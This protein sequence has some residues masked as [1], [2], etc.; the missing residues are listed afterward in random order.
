MLFA[1]PGWPTNNNPRSPASVTTQ[2][3]IKGR[4]PTNFAAI[5]IGTPMLLVVVLLLA[6]LMRHADGIKG[7]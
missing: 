3:S 6:N 1:V 7:H 5:F 4:E 2:R